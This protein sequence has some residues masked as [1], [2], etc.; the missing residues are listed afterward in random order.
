MQLE[1]TLGVSR[2]LRVRDMGLEPTTPTGTGDDQA[3]DRFL[4]PFSF[5]AKQRTSILKQLKK[6]RVGTDDDRRTY[7]IALE[8]EIGASQ[9]TAPESSNQLAA[10]ENA[11]SGEETS[12][13]D[14]TLQRIGEAASS[15]TEWLTQANES[16]RNTLQVH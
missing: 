16:S 15:L 11:V 10:I 8:F 2:L 13:Q 6:D 1:N 4:E 14:P 7:I 5:S 3:V 12:S 9:Q